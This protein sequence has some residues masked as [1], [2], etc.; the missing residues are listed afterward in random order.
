MQ[1]FLSPSS[2]PLNLSG[3][4]PENFKSKQTNIPEDCMPTGTKNHYSRRHEI[5]GRKWEVGFKS[6]SSL[7]PVFLPGESPWTEEPGGL[8]STRSQRVRHD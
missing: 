3:C 4:V 5:E 7:T 8:Q 1:I 2:H 6:S